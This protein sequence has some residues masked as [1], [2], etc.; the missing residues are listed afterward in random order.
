MNA[1]TIRISGKCS[2]L[3]S[4]SLHAEDGSQMGEDYQG[5]VPSFM[6]GGDED[7]IDLE[8]DLVSGRITNWRVPSM[9]ALKKT[10]GV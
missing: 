4:A 8:I 6:P 5:Y 7:Y 1:K 3:C 2:D 10:F 9:S